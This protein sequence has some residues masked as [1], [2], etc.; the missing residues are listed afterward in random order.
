M[1]LSFIVPVYNVQDYLEECYHSIITQV[2]D[3]CQIIL[4][5]D[6]STDSSGDLC[7]LLEKNHKNTI[8]VH[9]PNGG[10]ASARN[11]GLLKASGEY[12]AF[13]DADDRIANGSIKGI[14]Q[15]INNCGT[16]ICFMQAEK[17]YPDGERQQ[18]GDEIKRKGIEKKSKEDVLCYI[19]NRPKFPGSACTKVY[20]RSFLENNDLHFPYE[21]RVSEDLGFVRDCIMKAETYDALEFP[22]YEYRQNR[23]GSI[24]NTISNKSVDGLLYFIN[25]TIDT[26]SVG[27]TAV[28]PYG[29]YA[30]GFC[31]YEYGVLLFNYAFMNRTDMEEY[32]KK[33][34]D[35]QWI[36]KYSFTK[37]QKIIRLMVRMIG[38]I[39]TAHMLRLVYK[40]INQRKQ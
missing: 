2:T 30:L 27:Q 29:K 23:H 16:D 33:M 39:N 34:M 22:Y 26:Y 17:F 11:A 10:L 24:T 5:N 8:T 7:D 37:R 19:A 28:K 4:V 35:T 40:T 32:K 9:K 38:C 6:G 13:V 21:N 31:S 20:K 3:E 14:L 36:V 1:K 12:V 18:L 15:W 25:E